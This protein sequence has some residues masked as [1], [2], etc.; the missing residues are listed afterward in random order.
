MESMLIPIV[1]ITLSVISFAMAIKTVRD[2]LGSKA[3][4][5]SIDEGVLLLIKVPKENEQGPLGAEMFFSALHGLLQEKDADVGLF[6]FEIVAHSQGLSFYTY[7]PKKSRRFIENQI[8]AQYPTAEIDE[9]E[10]YAQTLLPDDAVVRGTEITLEKEQYYPLMTF[11]DFDVDPLAAITQSVGNLKGIE[12]AWFQ[13]VV[14][15]LAE[16][17]QEPGYEQI[18][19]LRTGKKK[20]TLAEFMKKEMAQNLGKLLLGV[21]QGVLVSPTK[22]HMAEAKKKD[23]EKYT[24]D[25]VA[26]KEVESIKKKV[27]LLG[28]E[29]NLRIVGVA[30]NE[31]EAQENV[32]SMVAALRQF[33]DE[34]NW[35]GRSGFIEEPDEVLADYQGRK[36]PRSS[37]N[38]FIL[39]T[40]EL[41]SIFHLPHVTVSTPNVEYIQSKKGEPPL[42]LPVDAEVKFA[43]TNFRDTEAT[44]GIKREDRRRHMYIIGKTGTGKSTLMRNMII[45]DIRNGEGLCVIDPHGDL[46]DYILDYIPEE[47]LDDVA[48]FNPDDVNHP[49]ALNMFELLD[50]DQKPLVASGMIEVFRKRF[51]FSWGPRMEHLLRNTFLTL[52]EIPNST[53]LGVTRMLIDRSYR[54]YIVNLVQ[55]P[56]IKD[57]W[58]NEYEQIASNEKMATEAVAPIQNRLG[59]FLANSMI[60]N[61]M[62]QAKGTLNLPDIM[63]QGKILLVNLS[64]GKLGEDN[65]DILGTFMV[66]RLWF[67]ALTRSSIPEDERRDFHVYIDEFQNFATSTFASILSESRKYRLNMV[68]A[69]QYMSQLDTEGSTAVRDAVF[70]NVGTMMCYVLGEEDSEIMAKEFEPVFETMDIINLGRFQLYLKIMIDDQQSQP[71]SAVGLPPIEDAVGSQEEVIERSRSNYGRPRDKVELAIRRWTE[72]TFAPGMD[73]EV[74]K[75]QQKERFRQPE[76]I[77]SQ[78]E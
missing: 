1:L 6:S 73:D 9:V 10:D 40:E 32:A 36:Q 33:A 57:F 29:V 24:M 72:R 7:V 26:K 70:G 77:K 60:R 45:Q 75:K 42:N 41:A 35:L 30:D 23:K 19:Y 51:E 54:R 8:Y 17:W 38:S 5:G 34:L 22:G 76:T 53:L 20:K 58:L 16:G 28:F 63:N 4:S 39:N 18:K 21:L 52:L 14:K 67:A 62:G 55:D 56:M 71:F 66:S 43:Q 47:R 78:T 3:E 49:V 48:I 37:D 61:M 65:A 59:P 11:P 44:F 50:P 27:S 68:L 46:F 31:D 2:H 12:R 25:D 13:M 64:K 15:P 69:H 74:V